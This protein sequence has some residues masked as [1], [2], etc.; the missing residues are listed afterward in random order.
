MNLPNVGKNMT[1]RIWQFLLWIVRHYSIEIGVSWLIY[2]SVVLYLQPSKMKQNRNKNRPSTNQNQPFFETRSRI[3]SVDWKCISGLDRPYIAWC[4]NLWSIEL[5]LNPLTL[6]KLINMFCTV[7]LD[8]DAKNGSKVLS[9]GQKSLELGISRIS[10]IRFFKLVYINRSIQ[11][12]NTW[13]RLS[14]SFF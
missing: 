11:I 7:F 14:K 13:H 9:R 1:H 2:I 8:S 10:Y 4:M 3:R 5:I 12:W 6:P